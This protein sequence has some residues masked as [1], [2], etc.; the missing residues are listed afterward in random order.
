MTSTSTHRRSS[1]EHAGVRIRAAEPED[2]AAYAAMLGEPSIV[3]GSLRLPLT[4]TS[5]SRAHFVERLGTNDV[6]V[7]T[8]EAVD[9]LD[10]A[11]HGVL[12]LE[13][14]ARRRHVGSIILLVPERHQGRGVGSALMAALLDL[15]DNWCQLHR[16]ELEVNVDNVAAISLY[17]R[18][19]FEVEATK[20]GDCFRD[21]AYVDGHVMGRIRP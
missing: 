8:A 16:V 5:T 2:A 14:R 18:F 15:A 19:G 6:H 12:E 4:S 9:S 17:R 13:R 20:R 21:G 1:A 10:F 3:S 7:L 11:G